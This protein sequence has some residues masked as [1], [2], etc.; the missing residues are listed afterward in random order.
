MIQ[1]FVLQ[2][3]STYVTAAATYTENTIVMI[4]T[5]LSILALS[6]QMARRYFMRV[7][8]KFTLRLAADIWWLLFVILRDASIFLMV[9]LGFTLFFPGIYQDFPIAMPFMPLSIDLFAIALVILLVKDTDEE[10]RYNLAITILV[11]LGTLLYLFGAIFVT[12][13]ATQLGVLPPTVSNSA[14]NIWGFINSNFNSVNNPALSIYT[15]Y[16]CFAVLAIAGLVALI[17]SIGGNEPRNT[18]T[19][20]PAPVEKQTEAPVKQ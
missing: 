17:Y 1:Y 11:S 9:F 6:I 7:L 12:E 5:L 14:S 10:P 18:I 20:N 3:V 8:R 15:F 13:S 4:L 2:A 16:I 19:V